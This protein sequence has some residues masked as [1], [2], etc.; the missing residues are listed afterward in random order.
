MTTLLVALFSAAAMAACDEP[1]VPLNLAEKAILE[2]RLDEARQALDE[3]E[4][5]LSCSP[6]ASPALLARLWLMEGA[7]AQ[8][9]GDQGAATEA[10]AS[11]RALDPGAWDADLG[12]A[13]HTQYLAAELPTGGEGSLVLQPPLTTFHAYVDGVRQSFPAELGAGLHLVQVLPPDGEALY[14]RVIAVRPG[15]EVALVHGLREGPRP[16]ARDNNRLP[17]PPELKPPRE[18][19]RPSRHLPVLGIGGGV[20]LVA[21]AGALVGAASQDG[22]M[23]TAATMEALDAAWGRQQLLGWGGYALLGAGLGMVTVEFAF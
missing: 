5:V 21:G 14:A 23:E 10:F 4:Q 18:P 15:E 19:A 11:S 9:S 22:A 12:P 13:L 2:A 8:F 1:A 20:A 3:V 7:W 6:P 17:P 16:V